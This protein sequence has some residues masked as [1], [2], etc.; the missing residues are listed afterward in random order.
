MPL[1]EHKIM[2]ENNIFSSPR[3]NMTKIVLVGDSGVGK[4]SIL[5]RFVNSRFNTDYT[6]TIGFNVVAKNFNID[7][8]DS[9]LL[10]FLD[11]AGEQRFAEVRKPC[12]IGVEIVI[13]IC[14]VTSKKS[15]TSIEKTWLP[16]FIKATASEKHLSPKV[17][18]IA[19]KCDLT[20]QKVLS[21]EDLEEAAFKMTVK[22]PQVTILK[23]ALM[24]SAK[25]NLNIT[26]IFGIS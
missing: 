8:N 12:Y 15:L 1:S 11:I 17:L 21:Q 6:M 5:N 9:E 2:L 23:P 25:E 14:D 26:E 19:N 4:S 10:V 7:K 20:D 24:L 3:K 16:E 22:F 18:L 13:A